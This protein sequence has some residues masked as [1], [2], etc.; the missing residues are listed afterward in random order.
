MRRQIDVSDEIY[1]RLESHARGFDTPE[2]VIERMLNFYDQNNDPDIPVASFNPS[3]P[4][5]KLNEQLDLIF[6]PVDELKFKELL[7]KIKT[8][9]IHI[10][11]T[12]GSKVI[13]TWRVKNFTESSSLKGNLLSG[14]LR[15][16]RER[17]IYK[18]E[19]VIDDRN[20][21]S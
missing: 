6:S 11:K 12:D 13:K 20:T 16:W 18:A 5:T 4:I 3:R 7:L 14:Y 1:G 2:N 9:Q 10:Y 19:V 17:G 21:A 8:A 15:G